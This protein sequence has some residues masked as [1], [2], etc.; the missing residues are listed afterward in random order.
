[1]AATDGVPGSELARLGL[2]VDGVISRTCS[3][4]LMR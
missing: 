4:S 1:M 3:V 2:D